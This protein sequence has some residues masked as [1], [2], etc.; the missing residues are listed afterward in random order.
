M[1]I[2]GIRWVGRATGLDAGKAE[3]MSMLRLFARGLAMLWLDKR[4]TGLVDSCEVLDEVIAPVTQDKPRCFCCGSLHEQDINRCPQ[5][6]AIIYW[7]K[8]GRDE[9]ITYVCEDV[10]VDMAGQT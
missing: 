5:C 3:E 6:G 1:A 8:G 4:G 9:R 7:K 10:S 2:L